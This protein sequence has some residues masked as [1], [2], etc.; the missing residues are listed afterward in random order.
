MLDGKGTGTIFS[1]GISGRISGSG[2][3]EKIFVLS[4]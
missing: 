1:L 2:H 3:G 4:I